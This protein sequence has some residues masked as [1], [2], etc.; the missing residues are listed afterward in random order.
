MLIVIWSLVGLY[1]AVVVLLRVG[2]VQH[3]LGARIGGALSET[4]G[5]EVSIGR[6]DVGMLNRVL[7]DDVEVLDL[8]GERLLSV[9]R[10]SVK[11]S[12]L[13]LL[14]GKVSI[15][16][17]QLFGMRA[18]LHKDETS[19]NYAFILDAF[20]SDESSES[21]PFDIRLN[22]LIIRRSEL[23]YN[24]IGLKNISAH[25]IA[26]KLSNDSLNIYVK[27]LSCTESRGIDLRRLSFR[28]VASQSSATLSD[29]NITL[30]SSQVQLSAEASYSLVRGDSLRIDDLAFSGQI[31]RSTLLLSDL[32]LFANA[33]LS[34]E[35]PFIFS[36]D[37]SGTDKGI[38][39]ER[40]DLSH[41]NDLSLSVSAAAERRSGSYDWS[42]NIEE[43]SLSGEGIV[44]IAKSIG[45]E[46]S[47]PAFSPLLGEI[48][49]TADASQEG[50]YLSAS[51]NLASDIGN[52]DMGLQRKGDLLRAEVEVDS[53][54]IAVLSGLSD[55]SSCSLSLSAEGIMSGKELST[56][57]AHTD[58]SSLT[59]KEHEYKELSLDADYARDKEL[60][61]SADISDDLGT[62]SAQIKSSNINLNKLS[63]TKFSYDEFKLPQTDFSIAASN[64]QPAALHLTERF[65][66]TAFDFSAEGS[67]E[68]NGIDN[69]KGSLHIS[70]FSMANEEESYMLKDLLINVESDP[71]G[72]KRFTC[73][74]D[75]ADLLI[76]GRFE[77]ATLFDSFSSAVVNQLPILPL[78]SRRPTNQFDI[79]ATFYP[80]AFPSQLL[81]IPLQFNEEAHF[82]AKLDDI[83]KALTINA[84]AKNFQYNGTDY[85]DNYLIVSSP[86][87]TIRTTLNANSRDEEGNTLQLA[88]HAK[89]FDNYVDSSIDFDSKSENHIKGSLNALADF[90]KRSPQGKEMATVNILPSQLLVADTIWTINP[91]ALTYYDNY[92]KIDNFSVRHNQQYIN[93]DGIAQRGAAD[94]IV[95]ETKEVNVA[96]IL[97]F[98]NFH[99]VDFDGLATGQA[100]L[101]A[102][103]DDPT[104]I[105]DMNV[106]DFHFES[107][108][109]GVAHLAI[110]YNFAEG[111]INIDAVAQEEEWRNTTIKGYVA[112]KEKDINLH[113]VPYGASVNFLSK[114]CKYFGSI[115]NARGWGELDVVGPLSTVQLHGQA[116]ITA[117]MYIDA[118]HTGYHLERQAVA[119]Y[120]DDITFLSDT[121]IDNRGQRGVVNGHLPHRHLGHFSYDLN[122]SA[123]NLLALDM[124]DFGEDAYLGTVYATGSCRIQAV[125]N[126]TRIDID[127]IP[128]EGSFLTYNATTPDRVS[129]TFIHWVDRSKNTPAASTAESDNLDNEAEQQRSMLSD[130]YIYFLLRCDD[131]SQLR[132]LMDDRTGDLISLNGNGVI[133]ATYYNKGAFNVYGNYLVNTG[134][135]RMTIQDVIQRDFTFKQGGTISFS[136]DPLESQI[137]LQAEYSLASVPLSD[138]NIGKSFSNNNVRVDCLM[139]ITGTAENPL[140]DFS[141]DLPTISSD[142]KQMIMSMFADNEELNQQVIYLIAIGRFLNQY[143]NNSSSALYSQTSLAMQ[144]FLSGTGSQQLNN[145]LE[146]VIGNKQWNFGA[147]ISPGEEGFN[148]AEYEGLVSGKMFNS[149][150]LFNGQF[151]YRDNPNASSS[152]IGDFDL[153]Y[154]LVPTGSIAVR[155]Y[156]ETNNR[157]FTKNTLT[158]QGVGLII[159]KDFSSWRDLFRSTKKAKFKEVE[160]DSLRTNL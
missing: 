2:A 21:K 148:D 124:Q 130:L 11:V 136:G 59:F 10:L 89:A 118:L 62:L 4:L 109:M 94:D 100:R 112:L 141:L 75:F 126:G 30:P 57:N 34:N 129:D 117:D 84:D 104:I 91:A 1:I 103:F 58:I 158:T 160:P 35:E 125:E 41:G 13:D 60:S 20:S 157:Y 43:L 137:N 65:P 159:K 74:S 78:K 48:H 132:I 36:A 150:L 122:I 87:D 98:I 19:C 33:D 156:N 32:H 115:T 76:D 120:D 27:R 52:I 23:S 111:R 147:N 155:I 80:T 81:G 102:L 24:T 83:N 64:L 149:R 140:V 119:F 53:I 42:A 79:Y 37:F 99:S 95:I 68:C 66:E 93:I 154:L 28:L 133:T 9:G 55:F 69:A 110:D 5:S 114:Y 92:L 85:Y 38:H 16:S 54:D 128:E 31:E 113:I 135:Y 121:I 22:S 139:N 77:Y 67:L 56:L 6:V 146:R 142:A 46:E 153:Q 12:L 123:N 138:I 73:Q 15:S 144:S 105:A 97:D 101:H 88:L 50:D 107:G 82:I 51:G 152:F 61:I 47:L 49:I 18:Q 17:A 90:N 63:A 151:G 8:Q 108:A 116:E 127:I 131:S 106:D 44:N 14:K 143:S 72:A 45:K 40:F 70:N 86:K 7:I 3:E 29:L 39:L 96:Y 71:H 134:T 25:I 145:V 26:N